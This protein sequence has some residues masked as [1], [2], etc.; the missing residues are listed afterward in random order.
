MQPLNCTV[1]H[2]RKCVKYYICGLLLFLVL[3][4]TALTQASSWTPPHQLTSSAPSNWFPNL[5]ADAQG[6]IHIVWA[7]QS[8]FAS[9]GDTAS[10]IDLLMYTRK[11]GD[12]WETANDI[13]RTGTG[14]YAPRASIAADQM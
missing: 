2:V 10:F 9:V 13:I 14:G 6:D 3:P 7:N 4:S 12:E 5:T 1:A 8:D 11:H